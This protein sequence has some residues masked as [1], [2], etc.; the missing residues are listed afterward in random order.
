MQTWFEVRINKMVN[1]PAKSTKKQQVLIIYL[2]VYEKII[3]T[4]KFNYFL[5][6]Y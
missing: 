3:D 2:I 6:S 5:N 1:F 4:L